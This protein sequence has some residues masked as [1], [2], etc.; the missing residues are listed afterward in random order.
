[1]WLIIVAAIT[2]FDL[3][4]AARSRSVASGARSSV[5]YT[6]LAECKKQKPSKLCSTRGGVSR[7]EH[8][9]AARQGP[10]I[11]D[12]FHEV[13]SGDT[14]ESVTTQSSTRRDRMPLEDYKPASSWVG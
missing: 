1:M 9:Q 2:N 10:F 14:V 3:T 8:L 11:E 13:R 12:A 6:K 5:N 4:C 7:P